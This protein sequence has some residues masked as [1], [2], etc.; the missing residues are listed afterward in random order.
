M[1]RVRRMGTVSALALGIAACAASLAASLVVG[2]DALSVADA[3]SALLGGD[4][5]QS[6][7]LI[8][9][10]IR[11]PRALAAAACGAALAGSGALLQTALNNDLASPGVMGVNAGAGMFALISG[12]L[13]PYAVA[14]RQ[15][16][17]FAGAL[18]ATAVVY[19]VARRAGASRTSLVLAGVAVSSL[20]RHARTRS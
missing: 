13:F 8:V 19:A 17:A 2:T 4:A 3:L 20:P 7:R 6:A 14:A 12:L 10:G 1:M 18:A 5:G 15:L 16:M 11:L 9:F